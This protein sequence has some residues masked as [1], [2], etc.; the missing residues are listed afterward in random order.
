[1]LTNDIELSQKKATITALNRCIETCTDGEK[2]YGAASA[3]ARDTTLK[4]IFRTYEVQRGEFVSALQTQIDRLGADHENEGTLRGTLHRGFTGARLQI[5][6]RNDAVLVDE[7]MRGDDAALRVYDKIL[8]EAA[9]MAEN[10]RLLITN[11]RDAILA[12]AAD[13][14]N[15]LAFPERKAG[16]ALGAPRA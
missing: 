9:A 11:Q 7:C 16:I 4:S 15:R 10:V 13:M 12:A 2:G 6:G 3:D 14:R 8:H 1:M 5:E